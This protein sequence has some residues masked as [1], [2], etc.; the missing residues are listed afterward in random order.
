MR[1][2]INRK[3]YDTETAEKVAHFDGADTLIEDLYRTT[4]GVFF[5]HGQGGFAPTIGVLLVKGE[6]IRP[7]SI[8]DVIAWLEKRQL[9]AELEALFP[10]ELEEA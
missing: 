8:D 3:V 5:L 7:M 4:K 1:T 9:V 2:I 10:D 6:L